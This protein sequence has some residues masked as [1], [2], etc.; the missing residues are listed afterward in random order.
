MNNDKDR[1]YYRRFLPHYQ[2]LFATYFVTFRLAESLPVNVVLRLIEEQQNKEKIIE[3]L[4]SKKEQSRMRK[5]LQQVYFEKFDEELDK[6]LFG[7]QWLKGPA[8]ADLVAK[9]IKIRDG[10]NYDLLACCIM[11]NHVHLVIDLAKISNVPRDTELSQNRRYPLTSVLR[12]LKG[13][14]AREANLRLNRQGAFWQHESYDHVIR[15]VKEL[16]RII[17][18]VLNNPV[19][20]RLVKSWQEWKWSYLKDGIL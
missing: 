13:S 17:V 2:P 10:K 1:I 8:V 19:K 3:K 11:P 12:L 4:S 15:N 9:K 14:S 20:A 7:P 18:Y 5:E 6:G 16:R